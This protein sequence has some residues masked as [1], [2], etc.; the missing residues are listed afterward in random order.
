[1][2]LFNPPIE[3]NYTIMNKELEFDT[4]DNPYVQVVWDDYAENFTQ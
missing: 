4:L 2:D 1:M 3:F